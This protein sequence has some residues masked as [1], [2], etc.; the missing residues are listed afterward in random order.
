MKQYF[1]PNHEIKPICTSSSKF[2]KKPLLCHPTL[3]IMSSTNTQ[4]EFF[5]QFIKTLMKGGTL[6]KASL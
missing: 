3:G 5:T 1:M 6:N 4:N 2:I